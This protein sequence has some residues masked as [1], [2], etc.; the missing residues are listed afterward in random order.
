M[1]AKELRNPQTIELTIEFPSTLPGN[2]NLPFPP[3]AEPFCLNVT[4]EWLEEKGYDADEY[5]L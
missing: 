4:R 2:E 1:V 5:T 3:E